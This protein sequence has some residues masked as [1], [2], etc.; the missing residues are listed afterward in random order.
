MQNCGFSPEVTPP[1]HLDTSK[2]DEFVESE[3]G[4]V[5]TDTSCLETVHE[6]E[7]SV[8]IMATHCC[9]DHNE[10]TS[11]LMVR[12][13]QDQEVRP[14]N[15]ANVLSPRKRQKVDIPE[16][17]STALEATESSIL[18][19]LKNYD[20]GVSSARTNPFNPYLCTN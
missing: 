10:E 16:E 9:S 7:I 8:K 20:E 17:S 11:S 2:A 12:I 15:D 3:S 18:D 4:M 5:S 1:S 13:A 14:I 19:W 6:V